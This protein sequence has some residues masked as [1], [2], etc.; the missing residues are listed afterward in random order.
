MNLG[1]NL[2]SRGRTK[3]G[4]LYASAVARIPSNSSKNA[5]AFGSATRSKHGSKKRNQKTRSS[6]NIGGSLPLAGGPSI[7][8]VVNPATLAN[9]VPKSKKLAAQI[10]GNSAAE[11]MLNNLISQRKK[12]AAS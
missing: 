12:L 8:N 4:G 3:A 9:Q 1:S 6:M 10:Y 7:I 2:R 11:N 5:G